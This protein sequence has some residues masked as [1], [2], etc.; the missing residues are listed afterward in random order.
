MCLRWNR[1]NKRVNDGHRKFCFQLQHGFLVTLC[2]LGLIMFHS[3]HYG[4]IYDVYC[5]L[6][7]FNLNIQPWQ[8]SQMTLKLGLSWTKRTGVFRVFIS[9]SLQYMFASLS[10]TL[11][12][13]MN[14]QN[15]FYWVQRN[16]RYHFCRTEPGNGCKYVN[17]GRQRETK[18]YGFY[19][20][21]QQKCVIVITHEVIIQS[22]FFFQHLYHP[23]F[24]VKK[25][26]FLFSVCSPSDTCSTR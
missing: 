2:W 17:K 20:L 3:R 22:N 12:E 5:F 7:F 8:P 21:I 1:T 9:S 15:R 18:W 6:F 25:Q 23:C 16:P 19:T 10:Q 4:F 14:S 26:T 11:Y 24:A 13:H